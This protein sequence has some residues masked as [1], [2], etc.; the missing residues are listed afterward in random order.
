MFIADE[1]GEGWDES[2]KALLLLGVSASWREFL[3]AHLGYQPVEKR[4]HTLRQ[5]QGERDRS[6]EIRVGIR[7]C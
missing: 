2:T 7:S 5:A 3:S 6:F 4:E 1:A